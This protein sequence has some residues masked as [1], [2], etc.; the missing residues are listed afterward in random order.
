MTEIS[1]INLAVGV[2][3][4][5]LLSVAKIDLIAGE[6]LRFRSNRLDELRLAE[7]GV[8]LLLL[9]RLHL[10]GVDLDRGVHAT[11]GDE[12]KN[13]RHGLILEL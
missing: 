10:E 7:V 2:T 12:T 5:V 4:G 8:Q 13:L 9:M 11:R 3:G 6:E 1:G